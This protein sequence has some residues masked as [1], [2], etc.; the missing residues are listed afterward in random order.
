RR[1]LER[2]GD[3]PEQRRPSAPVARF[4]AI[5]HGRCDPRRP[6]Q[7]NLGEAQ[8]LASPPDVCTVSLELVARLHALLLAT[9]TASLASLPA[10]GPSH[11]LTALAAAPPHRLPSCE[12]PRRPL[13]GPAQPQS[14]HFVGAP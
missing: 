4:Q 9:R 8:R 11:G 13:G 7:L 1:H 3:Q 10:L 5:D 12:P 2:L 14:A 6:R